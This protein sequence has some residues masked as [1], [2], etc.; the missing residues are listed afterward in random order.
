MAD[1]HR[2]AQVPGVPGYPV[3][4]PGTRAWEFLSISCG[5]LFACLGYPGSLRTN[6]AG[7]QCTLSALYP[8]RDR[9][10]GSYQVGQFLVL[11]GSASSSTVPGYYYQWQSWQVSAAVPGP[12]TR[13]P[14]VHT[15]TV[16]HPSKLLSAF[17]ITRGTR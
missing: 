14:R 2:I 1:D 13:V 8:G 16:Y 6:T 4:T 5:Q 7:T 11:G 12:G 10:T 3:L 9:G 15:V 17:Q